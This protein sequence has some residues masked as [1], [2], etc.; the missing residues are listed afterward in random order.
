MKKTIKAIFLL[1]FTVSVAAAQDSKV[2]LPPESTVYIIMPDTTS[3]TS[4]SFMEVYKKYWT[5]SNYKFIMPNEKKALTKPGNYFF[6]FNCTK[7]ESYGD[8][9]QVNIYIQIYLS[10]NTYKTEEVKKEM[11]NSEESILSYAL[12]M[13]NESRYYIGN[14]V[15]SRHFGSYYGLDTSRYDFYGNLTIWGP[16]VLKNYLQHM[17]ITINKKTSDSEKSS[18]INSKAQLE[19]LKNDTLYVGTYCVTPK[20]EHK[21]FKK[22]KYPYRVISAKELNKKIMTGDN[23]VYYVIY[24][25]DSQNKTIEI[26][27]SKTGKVIYFNHSTFSYIFKRKDMD[28]IMKSIENEGIE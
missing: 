10:L 13:D 18:A 2:N 27:N 1:V 4:K 3:E 16:G 8:K 28:K 11:V 19:K 12:P 14:F 5:F 15:P 9:G 7:L 6:G 22:Y 17:A 26:I 25:L 21:V 23:P 24:V 20:K